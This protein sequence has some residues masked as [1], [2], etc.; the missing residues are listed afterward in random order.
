MG[1]DRFLGIDILRDRTKRKLCAV[2]S[3]LISALL[4]KFRMQDC[5]VKSIPFDPYT[6]LTTEMSPKS[7]EAVGS[8]LYLATTTRPDISFA[9]GQVSQFCQ[10]PGSAHWNA[11]KGRLS[12][13]SL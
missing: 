10:N 9:V 7:E 1:A 3:Q 4:Q 13:L 8:L 5:N 6:H 11:V 2:Q 12:R